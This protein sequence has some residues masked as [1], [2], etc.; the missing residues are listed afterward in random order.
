MIRSDP[1]EAGH[2]RALR[3]LLFALVGWSALFVA[4][5]YSGPWEEKA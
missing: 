5:Q 1:M 4:S 3:A 2:V